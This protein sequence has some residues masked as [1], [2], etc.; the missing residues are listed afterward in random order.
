MNKNLLSPKMM[1]IGVFVIISGSLSTVYAQLNYG[2]N[3][4]FVGPQP[5]SS[6]TGTNPTVLIGPNFALEFF[7][8]GL[9]FWR[10]YPAP[11]N[12]NYKIFIDQT[13]KV[14][15][16]RK[17]TTYAFEVNGQI[18]STGGVVTLSEETLKKNILNL[19]DNRSVYFDKLMRLNGQ[20]YDKQISSDAG[21]EKEIADMVAA[22]KLNPQ[23]A[24]SALSALNE[25]KKT[26]HKKEYGFVAQ[27][28]Q[29]YF[30]ELVEKGEDGIYAIN[31]T[32][33]Y[34]EM[35]TG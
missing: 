13:G 33:L 20:L 17:P 25:S 3:H 32:I 26:V 29:E 19:S 16:G 11:Y 9:N 8:S 35:R 30:P 28:M 4:L 21:N 5:A 7:E 34:N 22:G 14:G 15:V 2:S 1:L 24:Q 27:E 12:G 31:Y 23:D 10:P 18:W 6:V